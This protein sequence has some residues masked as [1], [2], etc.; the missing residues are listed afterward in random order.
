MSDKASAVPD[1]TPTRIRRN[2]ACTSCRD[3]KVKCNASS[4]PDQSCYRC[5]KL[6]IQC[7]VD[8]SHK[9]TTRRSK[10]EELEKEVLTIKNAVQNAPGLTP[11]PTPHGRLSGPA[12]GP[13]PNLS[14]TTYSSLPERPRAPLPALPSPQNPEREAR[15]A[16]ATGAYLTPTSEPRQP[17]QPRALGSKVL[18]AEEVEYYFDQ[19]FKHFHPYF[20][21]V[22]IREPNRVYAACPIL[23][24]TIITVACRAY[25]CDAELFS[26]LAQN[27]PR[28]VWAVA[29]T[30]PLDLPAINALLV[31][32]AWRFPS[33]KNSGD[34]S[35]SYVAI[36]MNASLMPGLHTGR[37]AHRGIFKC[38]PS[39]DGN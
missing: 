10:L 26:F 8:R 6:G 11:S 23:F 30:P 20:P 21:I 16:P 29:M 38:L 18:P 36:A 31:L 25:A 37:G 32:S 17:T 5:C 27:L 28:E 14:P 33:A 12:S 39:Q 35:S 22:R 15:L 34:P 2:T 24:W 7:V 3:S 13:S 1:P 4:V 19:Y 9:R